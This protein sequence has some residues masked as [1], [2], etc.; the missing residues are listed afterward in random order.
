LGRYGRLGLLQSD[1]S[2][3]LKFCSDN[4]NAIAALEQ[5]K[6]I[7]AILGP[8]QYIS[9]LHWSSEDGLCFE[10]YPLG[11]LRSYYKTLQPRLPSLSNRVR[12]CQQVVEAVAYIHSKGVVHNDISASNMLVS[13]SMDIKVCDFGFSNMVGEDLMG[14]TEARYCRVRPFDEEGSTFLD[15]LFATGSLFYEILMGFRPY[16]DAGSTEALKQ[17]REHVFPSLE[18]VQPKCYAR[19]INNCWNE[20]YQSILNLQ[21]DLPLS[22]TESMSPDDVED[23]T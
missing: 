13:S 2:K 10:Y 20:Q 15:D 7:Y 9:H 3:I 21:H 11:S 8:H 23:E 1:R 12:W 5:E 19:V 14:G 18:S 4:K 22:L 16:E 6:R 17:Y